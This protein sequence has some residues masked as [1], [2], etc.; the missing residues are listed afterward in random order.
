MFCFLKQNK[1]YF[2]LQYAVHTQA[3]VSEGKFGVTTRSINAKYECDDGPNKAEAKKRYEMYGRIRATWGLPG[4]G[5]ENGC[6]N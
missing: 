4:P 5:I 2:C 3:G 1:N 6:Y